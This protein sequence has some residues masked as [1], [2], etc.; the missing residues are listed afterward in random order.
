[1]SPNKAA[2]QR[3]VT[4]AL[5]GASKIYWCYDCYQKR[6]VQK[7]V[8]KKKVNKKRTALDEV[9][10]SRKRRTKHADDVWVKKPR[11]TNDE[12][13]YTPET[14]KQKTTEETTDDIVFEAD[15]QGEEESEKEEEGCVDPDVEDD[16][17]TRFNG[18]VV[19]EEEDYEG[20]CLGCRTN[21]RVRGDIMGKFKKGATETVDRFSYVL[22]FRRQRTRV[23]TK[24]NVCDDTVNTVPP[25]KTIEREARKRKVDLG[26]A[27]RSVF[28]VIGLV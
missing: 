12:E 6:L 7:K 1:V 18:E 11:N 8:P 26:K 10:V 9:A 16:V 13:E 15:D 5:R 25:E 3:K 24:L 21:T 14:K 23:N 4:A 28:D 17:N 27:P 2:R 22:G 20:E 19:D